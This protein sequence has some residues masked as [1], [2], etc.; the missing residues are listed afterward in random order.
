VTERHIFD[1]FISFSTA[2]NPTRP[3]CLCCM[4][5][6][7][8]PLIGARVGTSL[9]RVTDRAESTRH[10]CFELTQLVQWY[11]SYDIENRFR[12]Q[13]SSIFS[14]YWL[15]SDTTCFYVYGKL[16][17]YVLCGFWVN[18]PNTQRL[19]VVLLRF[20]SLLLPLP[21]ENESIRIW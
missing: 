10:D 19:A 9:C 8:H 16:I 1:Y 11:K 15:M 7:V 3:C 6:R 2:T 20:V 17:S 5:C 4:P 18:G 13:M 14:W 21:T 12:L